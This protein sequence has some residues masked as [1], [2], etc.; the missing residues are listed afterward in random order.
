MNDGKTIFVCGSYSVGKEKIFL[1]ISESL[2]SK[3][4]VTRDKLNI[5]KCYEDETLT[6]SLTMNKNEALV[7]VLPLFEVRRSDVSNSFIFASLYLNFLF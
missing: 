5:L 7:H 4:C 2:N 1:A 6:E 3:I